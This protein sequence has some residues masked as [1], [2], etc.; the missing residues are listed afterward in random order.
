M[1]T[2]M[3]AGVTTEIQGTPTV[4]R[5]ETQKT[6]TETDEGLP[7]VKT[8]GNVTRGTLLLPDPS[9]RKMRNMTSIPLPAR[10]QVHIQLSFN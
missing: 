2:E 8:P 5:G 1:A 3:N 6:L 9:T 10:A 7:D 4:M